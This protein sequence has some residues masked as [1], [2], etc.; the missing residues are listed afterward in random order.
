MKNP[1]TIYRQRIL[2]VEKGRYLLNPEGK[3]K[4]IVV[5][6][7]YYRVGSSNLGF[8]S[9]YGILNEKRNI[10]CDRAFLPDNDLEEWFEKKGNYL[11]SL[12]TFKPIRDFQLIFFSISF[13]NDYLNV[14]KIIKYSGLDLLSNQRD[15]NTP[16]IIAGGIAV[17]ANPEPIAD[18]IDVFLLGDA[19]VL[20][21]S[22][23]EEI[24]DAA[25][26]E[27]KEFFLKIFKKLKGAYIPND[28]INM[29]SERK[30]EVKRLQ[31]MEESSSYSRII[32]PLTE[33]SS[34]H[35]VEM[36]RGCA[37]SCRFCLLGNYY[38]KPRMKSIDKLFEHIDSR[39]LY[40]HKIGLISCFIGRGDYIN[41][42]SKG[43]KERKLSASFSSIRFEDLNDEFVK[44][45][46]E[47][48]Q[49]TV[50]LAPECGDESLRNKAGKQIEDDVIIKGIISLAKA[51]I[52]SIKLYFMIGFPGETTDDLKAIYKLVKKINNE[53]ERNNLNFQIFISASSFVPKAFTPLQWSAMEDERRLKEKISLLRNLF[54]KINNVRFNCDLPKFAKI[55]ALLSRG[56]RK[57]GR[58][59]Q[60]AFSYKGDW[61]RA[62]RESDV[63]ADY[64][65]YRT[66]K[67]DEIFPWDFIDTGTKK[68]DLYAVYEKY[69]KN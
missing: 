40:T 24:I 9:V 33:F 10:I 41:N 51:G 21:N 19:E 22:F 5:Y 27:G 67:K 31:N 4:S 46:A 15:E 34:M 1:L 62:M 47:S 43:I 57:V 25:G 64:Y 23:C 37:S 13:E 2:S 66:R 48:G 17:S 61:R 44:L 69:F 7:N 29:E 56:D 36:S 45:I 55:Q 20:L 26:G 63:N 65:V 6:P 3:V 16:L 42:L 59:L 52:R 32:S 60:N 68:S 30:V 54:A 38:G 53:G 18:F 14:L 58:I 50:T 28:S 12:D 35:L 11:H 8:Q 39:L 49:K